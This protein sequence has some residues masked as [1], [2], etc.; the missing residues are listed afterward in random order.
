MKSFL[1]VANHL[2]D[3]KTTFKTLNNVEF[4]LKMNYYIIAPKK[5]NTNW[6]KTVFNEVKYR[7]FNV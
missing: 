7:K 4:K 2:N 5:I 3:M 6:Q 1:K